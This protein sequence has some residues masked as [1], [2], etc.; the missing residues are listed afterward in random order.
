MANLM[1]AGAVTTDAGASSSSSV[2]ISAS[3]GT[4]TPVKLE[5]SEDGRAT[6]TATVVA[7]VNAALVV[8]SSASV[9]SSAACL[10]WSSDSLAWSVSCV[11]WNAVS[12]SL[13]QILEA[14]RSSPSVS[15]FHVKHSIWTAASAAL[16]NEPWLF[17]LSLDLFQ[18]GL[19]GLELGLF[20]LE[21]LVSVETQSPIP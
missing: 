13:A 16:V 19:F 2:S 3:S 14:S 12:N 5:P 20:V 10:A 15:V 11:L 8:S 7:L 17:E 9:C 21:S 18:R 6:A 1:A 4:L